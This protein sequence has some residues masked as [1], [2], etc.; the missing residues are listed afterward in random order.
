MKNTILAIAC[1]GLFAC[2][3]SAPVAPDTFTQAA[4]SWEGAPVEDM[5]RTWGP[6][7]SQSEATERRLGLTHWRSYAVSGG[8]GTGGDRGR[9]CQVNAY[10]DATGIIERVEV[11]STNCDEY[12]GDRLDALFRVE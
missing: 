2:S 3:A 1:I 12:F 4:T 5:I 9:R 8:I 6:P 11:N 7:A 10:T